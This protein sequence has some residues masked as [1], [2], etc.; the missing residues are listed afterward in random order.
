MVKYYRLVCN[1]ST[2][3]YLIFQTITNHPYNFDKIYVYLLDNFYLADQF[4]KQ[5]IPIPLVLVCITNSSR[6]HQSD[7]ISYKLH[8]HIL[9]GNVVVLEIR[10]VYSFSAESFV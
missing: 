4:E 1:F 2:H 8:K 6:C 3:S 10:L 7:D 5:G 9:T